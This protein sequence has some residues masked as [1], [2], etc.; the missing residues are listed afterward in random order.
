MQAWLNTLFNTPGADYTAFLLFIAA[1]AG[2]SIVTQ[3]IRHFKGL[4]KYEKEHQVAIS[5]ALV[6]GMSL[7]T[8]AAEYILNN[9]SGPI[10]ATV[11]KHCAIIL[12]AAH[13]VYWVSVNPF[14]TKKVLPF[15]EDMA[16]IKQ[17]RAPQPATDSAGVPETF[18][19]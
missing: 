6:T 13:L 19:D 2:V 1:G 15:L 9:G 10:L 12:S 16:M 4:T 17:I 18:P 7:A 8:G 3:V 5:R 14:Y 11:L